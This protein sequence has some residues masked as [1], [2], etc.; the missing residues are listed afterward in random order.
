MTKLKVTVENALIAHKGADEKGKKLL[1][2]LLGKENFVVRPI[3]ERV[4][5]FEDACDVLGIDSGDV[6][7][8]DED[9]TDPDEINTN[10]YLKLRTII[11]ALNEGWTA[12]FNNP[13]QYKY[14]PWLKSNG[15]GLGLSYDDDVCDRSYSYVGSRLYLKSAELAKYVGT[16]FIEIYNQFNN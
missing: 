8:Y 5:S 14:Y 10:A 4:K 13:N 2:D 16:Q 12:D 15:S 3:M 6:L 7:V 1:E 11:K 9:T